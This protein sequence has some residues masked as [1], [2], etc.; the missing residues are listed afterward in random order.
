M[1]SLGAGDAARL[2]ALIDT[3]P[4]TN[5]FLGSRVRQF[6]LDPV[7]LGCQVLGYERRGRLVAALHCGVNL[8][9]LG[10][11]GEAMDAFVDQLGPRVHTQSIVG[12]A[13]A[14]P[15]FHARLVR[16]WG[17]SWASP[18]SVREHQ[19]V[20]RLD[21]DALGRRDE[22]VRRVTVAQADAYFAA[23]VRMYN[24]EVGVS[25]LDATN[26]YRFYVHGLIRQGRSFGAEEDGRFWFKADV[27][28]TYGPYCQ[29][30]GVWLAPDL[31]GRGL[32]E[33]AVAQ[34]VALIREAFPVVTLYV[35][36]FNT[37]A[38]RVYQ[39]LGFTT[40]G[41]LATILF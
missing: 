39:R 33:P 20:M 37:R 16:R 17:S 30:Q 25:P 12:R 10:E 21:T 9:L 7:T 32:A 36:S 11:D 4:A 8:Y 5:I 13:G 3:D 19:P 34:A 24:E 41:E 29:M 2:G 38:V 22:R 26:S 23:A 31:R 28:A 27:G 18:R 40:V 15:D 6:G 35:N 14:V 1:V